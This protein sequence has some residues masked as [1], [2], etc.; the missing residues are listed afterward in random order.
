[1]RKMVATLANCSYSGA[2]IG[3]GDAAPGAFGSLPRLCK[4]TL[5]TRSMLQPE[6]ASRTRSSILI[7]ESN[8]VTNFWPCRGENVTVGF[9]L[10]EKP[11]PPLY[12]LSG[13]PSMPN[14]AFPPMDDSNEN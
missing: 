4:H 5:R 1:M 14:T 11:I 6:P 9:S 2:W 10:I 8:C 12:S 7:G 3:V 13:V